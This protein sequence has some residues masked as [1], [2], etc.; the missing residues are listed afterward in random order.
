MDGGGGTIWNIANNLVIHAA[1]VDSS[2]SNRFDG[3]M[4]VSGGFLGKLAIHLTGPFEEWTMAGEMNLTGVGAAAFPIER[5]AGSRM[6]VTGDVNVEH[7]VRVTAD[8]TFENSSVVSLDDAATLLQFTGRTLVRS[9]AT[10]NGN[11]TLENGTAGELVLADNVSLGG[12]GLSNRG[13]LEVGNSAGTVAVDRFRNHSSGTWLVEIGG[14]LPGNFDR[15]LMGGEA[16]L[17]GLIEVDLID[18]GSGL[19]LPEIGDTFTVLTAFGGVSGTFENNPIS[20]A[21]GQHFHWSVLYTP[22]D[23]VL[24]LVDITSAVPESASWVLGLLAVTITLAGS[25]RHRRVCR[26]C[27]K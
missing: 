23:V 11:G 5:L 25:R 17:A 4:N 18:A 1:S 27:P 21:V 8:A 24:E 12:V 13:L 14:L 16:T 3:V 20:T 10:F 6:R 2:I 19:F 9:N 26:A 22:Q 7:R 15:L